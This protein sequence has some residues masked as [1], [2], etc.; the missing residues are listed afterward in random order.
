MYLLLVITGIFL[1]LYAVL[2][3]CYRKWFLQLTP[4]V[5]PGKVVPAT[6]FSII[7][8]ARDEEDHI[9]QCVRCIMEQDY[10]AELF[11]VIVIDDH[12]TDATAAI[13]QTLQQKHSNLQLVQLA[14]EIQGQQLNSYKKKAI[15]T[16][17]GRCQGDWIITTDA[18]CTIGN[19]WLLSFAAYIQQHRPVFVAAPVLFTNTG[20]FTGIFQCLDFMSMQGITAAAVSAGFHSMC[21]G[22]NLAYSKEAFLKVGG[23]SG[24]DN[25][26]SGDDMLL[27]HKIKKVYPQQIGYLFTP[28]AIVRT[29]PMP[30]WKSFFNQRIRWASK[31]DKYQDKGITAVLALVYLFNLFLVVL[32]VAGLWQV[33]LLWAGLAMI[34][35]KTVV[36]L[37]FMRPV[38]RFYGQLP[39]LNWFAVMQP[40]H[41]LYIII[42]GWLGKFGKYQWKGRTV[43]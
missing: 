33:T 43:K 34:A 26:A 7:I 19:L 41:I 9:G 42:A 21:N 28:K 39:L 29:A 18:D 3:I 23:F 14:H 37:S 2:I 13:I 24:I 35:L 11:E 5:L 30:D 17:I 1:A 38:A 31:A 4:Y 12:S 22:A 25:I 15:E 16:A 27:M 8:P 10:P 20:N 32:L 40:F 6:R 36:E